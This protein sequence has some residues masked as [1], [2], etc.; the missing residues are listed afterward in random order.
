MIKSAFVIA[1]CS[2]LAVVAL[3]AVKASASATVARAPL[4]GLSQDFMLVPDLSGQDA[5]VAVAFSS[6]EVLEDWDFTLRTRP[7]KCRFNR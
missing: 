4:A 6:T 5:S 1:S 2:L 7:P 3:L